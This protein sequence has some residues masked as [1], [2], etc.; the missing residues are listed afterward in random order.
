[1]D[2]E[3]VDALIMAC[4]VFEGGLIIVSHDQQLISSVGEELYVLQNQQLIRL[5]GDFQ[6]YKK[7]VLR[8]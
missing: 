5:K 6:T 8:L 3:T 4:S 2:L 1:M 7:T